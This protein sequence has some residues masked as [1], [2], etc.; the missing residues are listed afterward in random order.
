M[1]TSKEKRANILNFDRG[2]DWVSPAEQRRLEEER[3]RQEEEDRRRIESAG[4]PNTRGRYRA[5]DEQPAEDQGIIGALVD[6]IQSGLQ[7]S[8]SGGLTVVADSDATE[9]AVGID[10]AI[11]ALLSG[12]GG[13]AGVYAQ[14][15]A[16]TNLPG[17]IEEQTQ[18]IRD[19]AAEQFAARE[20]NERALAPAYNRFMSER[21]WLG[22]QGTEAVFDAA[23]SLSSSLSVFGGPLGGIGV[24]DVYAQTYAEMRRAGFSKEEAEQRATLQAAPEG[25]GFIP[26]GKFLQRIPLVD[27]ATRR[28]TSAVASPLVRGTTRIGQTVAG[29]AVEEGLTQI[30]QTEA[31]RLLAT[32]SDNERLAAFADKQLPTSASQ[33]FAEVFRAA[34]AG[35][36]GGAAIGTPQTLFNEMAEAGRRT[37]EMNQLAEDA[38]KRTKTR[39][40]RAQEL[41]N[42]PSLDQAFEQNEANA[43]DEQTIQD[44]LEAGFRTMELTRQAEQMAQSNPMAAGLLSAG[45]TNVTP[46]QI[47]AEREA[48]AEAAKPAWQRSVEAVQAQRQG[49]AQPL[50]GAGTGVPAPQAP[51]R[52]GRRSAA[53]VA[54]D[55]ASETPASTLTAEQLRGIAGLS[56]NTNTR[57]D[58]TAG[59][60]IRAVRDKLGPK[61][62]NSIGK[63]MRDGNL[64]VVDDVS[65]IPGNAN[66]AGAGFYDGQKTYIVANR[67]DPENI[68][69]DVLTVAAHE[70]KHAAD[71]GGQ[72][73]KPTLGE[74]I[75]T[76]ANTA[77]NKK[78]EDAAA[79]GNAAARAAVEAAK[80]GST[81]ETYALELPAYFINAQLAAR[82]QKGVGARLAGNVVSAVRT[83]YRRAKGGD[84][85]VSLNDVAYMSDRL[86]EEAAISGQPMQGNLQNPL[87]MVMGEQAPG[88]AQAKA[89]GRTF[90]DVDGKEKFVT[91]D[92][93]STLNLADN[94][95]NTLNSAEGAVPARALLNHPELFDAY[96]KLGDA[97][98]QVSDRLGMGASYDEN[99]NRV[100]IG[101]ELWDRRTTPQGNDQLRGFILH[102]LQ[103][104]V[105]GMEDFARGGSPEDFMTKTEVAA[106][107][108]YNNSITALMRYADRL[109]K[110]SDLPRD[111]SGQVKFTAE[112]ILR[113]NI[114]VREGWLDI[115]DDLE[116]NGN[117]NN[118]MAS[119]IADAR[120]QFDKASELGRATR[121][122]QER[123]YDKYARLRGEQESYFVQ[124]ARNTPQEDLPIDPTSTY[125]G[126][127]IVSSQIGSNPL[128]VNLDQLKRS[129][130]KMKEPTNFVYTSLLDYTGGLGREIAAM[131]ENADG[132]AALYSHRAMNSYANMEQQ[133]G[134]MA[135]RGVKEGRYKN[136]KE[137]KDT[138]RKDLETKLDAIAK[139]P[140]PA[141]RESAL[142]S[143]IRENPY[144]APAA[145]AISQINQLSKTLLGQM[146]ENNPNPTAEEL[147]R[148]STLA[149]NMFSYSTRM[150]AAFQ[151]Q[152]GRK[153]SERLIADYEAANEALAK[154]KDIGSRQRD[155]FTTY[156]NAMK[157]L[158]DNDLTIPD[159]ES[160]YNLKTE[161]VNNLYDT[162]V[163]DARRAR[164]VAME[165][166]LRDGMT[167]AEAR[168][169]ATETL[170]DG[171]LAR[172][173][174]TN[175]EYESKA[176]DLI[177][178]MLGVAESTGP[179]ANYYRG[180][181]QDRSI[182]EQRERVP[183]EIRQLFGEITDPATRL[184]V[185]IAKQGELAARTR[186]LLDLRDMGGVVIPKAEAG[187]P[188]TEN[189]SVALDGTTYGPLDGYRTTPEVGRAIS[190][191]LEMFSSFGDTLAKTYL[192]AAR[193]GENTLGKGIKGLQKAAGW[194]KLWSIALEPFGIIMNGLGSP[195]MLAANGVTSPSAILGGART[196][197]ESIVDT[198]V[199]GR[200][201]L[202]PELEDAIKYGILDSARVQEIRRTPQKFVKQLIN[203]RPEAV[204]TAQRAAGTTL[205]TTVETFAI[206]DAWVKVA[207]FRDRTD[208]LSRFYQ[209]EGVNKSEDE[210]KQEAADTIKDTNITY[211]RTLP[212][213]R[214][215]ESTGLT[216]FLPY[217]ASVP[218][219]LAYNT[220]VAYK[221]FIRA[222]DAKTME[223]KM[224]L[225]IP[226]MK[227]LAGTTAATAGM[228]YGMQALA[229]ALN[230]DD[231]E[232]MNEAKKVLRPDARFSDSVY[233]GEDSK[234]N[235]LFF[236][237]SRIDPYG[238]VNDM[239]R[240]LTDDSITTEQAV[241]YTKDAL[242]DLLFTNRLT[243]AAASTV[244]SLITDDEIRDNETK[245]ERIAPKQMN[246]AKEM[247]LKLGVKYDTANSLIKVLDT[248]TPGWFDSL[249][250][251][252]PKVKDPKDGAYEFLGDM[253]RWSGGRLDKADPGSYVAQ[254]GREIKDAKKEGRKRVDDAL[255]TGAEPG[256]VA[257]VIQDSD[258]ELFDKM[259]RLREVYEGMTD[260]L[261]YSPNKAREVL[262][263]KGSLTAIDVANIA[264]GRIKADTE[265]EL[266]KK[267]GLTLS[268]SSLEQRSKQREER[269]T[270]E[271]LK[272][273]KKKREELIKQL[274]A[275]G[276]K[277][278][279]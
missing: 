257:S 3:L 266:I 237:L 70:T 82:D 151:G 147:K 125:Q 116:N 223:G 10:D 57:S 269:Q 183:E 194:Q 24:A 209:A 224:A 126:E 148:M 121:E 261:D 12:R 89:E 97:E 55:A 93:T 274:K 28:L 247:M 140:N 196:G 88:F 123:A 243:S 115:F 225:G 181:R 174:P 152:P 179:I 170:I 200:G 159:E 100:L 1:A 91:A 119:I 59:S 255:R 66:E 233:L 144:Y 83:A 265:D 220:V 34:K 189:F 19:E 260:G 201:E 254:L 279:E 219:S 139:L 131:R 129:M 206:A 226:A 107:R 30:A 231:E 13:P 162:W 246:E 113:G 64:V 208:A 98:V 92:N 241:D 118:T 216:S 50:V 188:G 65:E 53:A 234:D 165:Q 7:G 157:Y 8:A 14:Q 75:G 167:Q 252:N 222:K 138:I 110:G 102:E 169:Y 149:N 22:K 63:L 236:R 244:G 137:A 40:E 56:M 45:A 49:P 171:L 182:L 72:A 184:A 135:K 175:A 42:L 248:M 172:Q 228:V 36:V 44:E 124:D 270:D 96:P 31:D 33:Y 154:G 192:D 17:R 271:E 221:D 128:A 239:F 191:N 213:V 259:T 20:A 95:V 101:R 41:A 104:G 155:N 199:N 205:R 61:N 38:D 204:N 268:K 73:L 9:A 251:N 68:I 11:S 212:I 273:E 262:K 46:E 215:A 176:N 277:V 43:P 230:G 242:K 133:I 106:S 160:I 25:I 37:A 173:A 187:L 67:L 112:S 143:L 48:A 71:V 163:G 111:V 177:K 210:I 77:L 79:G 105:Q 207:A 27:T 240:I 202:S 117:M 186:L 87:A 263:E 150:Y 21:G 99:A 197:L 264:R 278:G 267:L 211:G 193:T 39:I 80:A 86:L 69:G 153:H 275:M 146:L 120:K 60:V 142:A 134:N 218:R 258:N 109:Y 4:R 190:E 2:A 141:R 253:V 217:F 180:L 235:P 51:R 52:R 178:G 84:I 164:T 58:L 5:L 136:V 35:G 23:G 103:H 245:L 62:V 122:A 18:P 76:Q 127:P 272:A 185:T 198:A 132:T 232:K 250:P 256:E 81:P 94:V 32:M 78:I 227:R 156:R 214:A 47:R 85:D 249:D 54:A 114:S 74:F 90:M 6:R 229:A 145:D 26:A 158:I 166:G 276:Y 15:A 238:P 108:R 168:E 203:E 16:I 29:E 195:I 161:Q 130:Q